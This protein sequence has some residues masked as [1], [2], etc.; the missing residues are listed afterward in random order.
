VIDAE[1]REHGETETRI[2]STIVVLCAL[3]FPVSS[4]VNYTNA[5]QQK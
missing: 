4:S 2:V 3:G 5:I 1:T